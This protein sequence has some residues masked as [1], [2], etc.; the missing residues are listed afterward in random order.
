ME[1]ELHYDSVNCYD[2]IFDGALCQEETQEAIVPD[3]CPDILRIVDSQAQAFLTGT[4]VKEGSFSV[5]GNVKVWVFYLPE[6]S[7]N[8]HKLEVAL[9]FVIQKELSAI[10]SQC[11]AVVSPRVRWAQA[12]ALNPRKILVRVD[13]AADTKLYHP[14][15][16]SFCGGTIAPEQEIQQLLECINTDIPVSVQ[17]KDF[18]VNEEVDFG[19]ASGS[20]QLFGIRGDGFC[21]ESKLIGSKLIV[22]GTLEL[23]ALFCVSGELK[24]VH[25]GIPFSQIMEVSNVGEDHLNEVRI[26]LKEISAHITSDS[27]LS[28]EVSAELLIQAVTWEHRQFTVLK[29]VYSI[30]RNMP[31]SLQ[32]CQAQRTLEH[33]THTLPVRELLETASMVRSV[34]HYWA[35]LGNIQFSREGEQGIFS[36]EV[37]FNIIYLD[38][39]GELQSLNKRITLQCRCDTSSADRYSCW[40]SAPK[41]LYVSPA[42]GGLEVRC[43]LCFHC[44]ISQDCSTEMIASASFEVEHDS[45]EERRPSIVLRLA[46]PG[47]RLW[48]LAKKYRTTGDEIMSANALDSEVLPLGQMLLIP[49]IR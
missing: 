9:P 35:D 4:Q 37:Q 47:E 44:H 14:E 46:S 24:N 29:D 23:D 13:L 49:R 28:A 42:A 10:S 36:A 3:A 40:C 22:K 11:L 17:Q 48:D 7:P 1:L 25:T 8:V 5:T 32:V 16:R 27:Q 15:V 38:D 43:T 34:C 20:A 12:S 6:G 39:G 2:I 21:S 45:K 26:A 18:T 33:L 19:P 31:V 30:N 41:D